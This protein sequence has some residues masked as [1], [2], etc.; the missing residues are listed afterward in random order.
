MGLLRDR[1]KRTCEEQS[2]DPESLG[3]SI[4]VFLEPGDE[5]V[6]EA[7]GLGVPIV[8]TPSEAAERINESAQMGVTMLELVPVPFAEN[9]M[10][11]MA[12]LVEVLDS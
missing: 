3:K 6:A 4:G 11:Y 1:V 8:G 12:E 10:D 2:R 7:T 5:G 9:T